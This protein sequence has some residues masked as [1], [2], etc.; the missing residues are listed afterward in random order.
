MLLLANKYG[1]ENPPVQWGNAFSF[2]DLPGG[3]ANFAEM[4]PKVRIGS[5][6]CTHWALRHSALCYNNAKTDD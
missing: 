1:Y 3:F 4:L 2:S 5:Y 6:S